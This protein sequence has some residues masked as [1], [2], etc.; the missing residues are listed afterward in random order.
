MAEQIGIQSKNI[1]IAVNGSANLLVGRGLVVFDVNGG[2]ECVVCAVSYWC[3]E[4]IATVGDNI[5]K[6]S[7]SGDGQTVTVTNLNSE[8]VSV[9]YR[10]FLHA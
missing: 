10:R 8:K 5:I 4:T 9:T 3:V 1:E 7:A 2:Y 6:V